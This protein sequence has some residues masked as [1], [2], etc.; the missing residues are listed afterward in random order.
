[1]QFISLT[2]AND[3]E[4]ET[5]RYWLQLD[6]NENELEHLRAAIAGADEE[7]TYEVAANDTAVPESEVDILVKHTGCGY[8]TYENKVTGVLE[9]PDDFDC[10]QLYK[11]GV[12][13][14]FKA[15]ASA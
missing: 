1:V 3:H 11:G 7:E 6:G 13:G 8:T 10:D 5:W 9:L 4:G 15:A 2:E 12:A 14:L